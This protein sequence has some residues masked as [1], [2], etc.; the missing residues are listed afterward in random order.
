MEDESNIE[1][2]LNKRLVTI[3][4][5][6]NRKQIKSRVIY[7][8]VLKRLMVVPEKNNHKDAGFRISS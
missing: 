1:K 5:V 6:Y 3:K 4:L 2:S 8:F 7:F